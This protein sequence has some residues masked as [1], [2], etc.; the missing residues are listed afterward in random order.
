MKR[1][2]LP[3]LL[4]STFFATGCGDSANHKGTTATKSTENLS[5]EEKL[6][7]TLEAKGLSLC[8]S[9][10]WIE[11]M[12]AE[13]RQTIEKEKPDMNIVDRTSLLENVRDEKWSAYCKEHQLPDSIR[14][15]ING[16]G[17]ES[18]K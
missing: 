16:F 3:C 15:S 6:N 12:E 18:C 14:A 17:F 7:K 11:D 5:V 1:F 2:L 8:D 10:H 4:I 9:Y 13:T